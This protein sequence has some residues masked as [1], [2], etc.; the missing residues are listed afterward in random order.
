MTKQAQMNMLINYTV[1]ATTK[2]LAD[3]NCFHFELQIVLRTFHEPKRMLQAMGSWLTK[4]LSTALY[5]P[6]PEYL[7]DPNPIALKK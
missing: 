5:D 3:L 4:V 1:T 2:K 7:P 6:I